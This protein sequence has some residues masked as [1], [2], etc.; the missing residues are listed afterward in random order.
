[1]T[2]RELLSVTPGSVVDLDRAAGA[3]VDVLAN[4]TIIA[5]G[6]VVVIDD[7]FGIRILEINQHAAG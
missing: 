7:E 6:E 4:G 2:L 5:R 3:M 1:M